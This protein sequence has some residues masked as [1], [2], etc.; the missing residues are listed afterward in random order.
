MPCPCTWWARHVRTSPQ[1]HPRP[2]ARN[3]EYLDYYRTY[4]QPAS[5][6]HSTSPSG[7]RALGAGEY[8]LSQGHET[9][10]AQP[11]EEH[12]PGV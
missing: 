6:G 3:Q 2:A 4:G 7:F 8:R 12:Q 9:H 1:V 10:S 11:I 5:Q